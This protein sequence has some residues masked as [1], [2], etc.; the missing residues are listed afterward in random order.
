MEACDV[1]VSV[2]P[3]PKQPSKVSFLLEIIS[4]AYD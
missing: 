4:N 1:F 3:K 2:K